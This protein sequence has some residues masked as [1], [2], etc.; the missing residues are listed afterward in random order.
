[1]NTLNQTAKDFTVRLTVRPLRLAFYL[2]KPDPEKIAKIVKY[3]CS[4][5]GGIYN[6]IIVTNERSNSELAGL[7]ALFDPDLG[8]GM[9]NEVL[10]KANVPE[11]RM[12]QFAQLG[13]RGQLVGC[14]ISLVLAHLFETRFRFE[15]RYP[16]KAL[17]LDEHG[18]SLLS[19]IVYFGTFPR[20]KG[21]SYGMDYQT[22][23]QPRKISGLGNWKAKESPLDYLSP[24]ALT[25]YH[26]RARAKFY[27]CPIVFLFDGE[28]QEDCLDFWNLRALGLPV[29]GLPLECVDPWRLNLASYLEPYATPWVRGESRQLLIQKSRK[30]SESKFSYGCSA[31]E[32]VLKGIQAV[33]G[34]G[35]PRLG[36]PEY[37]YSDHCGPTDISS[38]SADLEIPLHNQSLRWRSLDPEFAEGRAVGFGLLWANDVEI[39]DYNP[40]RYRRA[41]LF[42]NIPVKTTVSL[43]DLPGAREL[44]RTNKGLVH[45]ASHPEDGV[46]Y[47]V[48][49]GSEV[50][51]DWLASKGI[52][53]K[54]SDKSELVDR[55]LLNLGGVHGATILKLDGFRKVLD[56]IGK[57]GSLRKSE[58]EKQLRESLRQSDM[59]HRD[60]SEAFKRLVSDG[61]MTPGLVFKCKHCLRSAWYPLEGI[62]RKFAC[63]Y[64]LEM[65]E[66]G[67]LDKSNEWSYKTLGVFGIPRSIEGSI[68]TALTLI[69]FTNHF[70]PNCS[71]LF[72]SRLETGDYSCEIDLVLLRKTNVWWEVGWRAL[73]AECKT[74]RSFKQKDIAKL[75]RTARALPGTV[76]VLSSLREAD[77]FD[78][79]EKDR[80]Q[81]LAEWG[82]KPHIGDKWLHPVVILTKIELQSYFCP[83]QCWSNWPRPLQRIAKRYRHVDSYEELAE[84]T[85]MA[86]LG[87]NSWHDWFEK[88][89]L[90]K[91]KSR[92]RSS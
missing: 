71:I 73:I 26:I 24:I 83:P 23:F 44:W 91:R 43:V 84:C 70:D 49:S 60:A 76:I 59:I 81:K 8:V 74:E 48:P 58:I 38:R 28:A 79:Q 4:V 22:V 21:M 62:S 14:D 82:R 45:Y 55:L 27:F 15:Q 63:R 87:M 19:N 10:Y 65:N 86:Y 13:K 12:A 20:P 31:I 29:F 88:K 46:Y 17:I 80:L 42:P 37:W 41:S 53:A 39:G 35:F 85:Q 6:P 90:K 1:V 67:T 77:Q 3:C 52:V 72:P 51:T 75:R 18:S 47:Q 40:D 50:V 54:K 61:V 16:P 69:F 11:H 30:L 34:I 78:Q 64:C 57:H 9:D 25:R 89:F 66:V 7:L 36:K 92:R 2:K 5:W 33:R 68:A 32:S 56:L